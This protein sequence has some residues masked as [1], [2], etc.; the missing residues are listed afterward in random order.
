[1]IFLLK[2]QN[3]QNLF[4][5]PHLIMARDDLKWLNFAKWV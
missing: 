2:Y 4:E 3:C 5:H 1:M